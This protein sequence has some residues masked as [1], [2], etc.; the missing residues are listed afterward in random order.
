MV[1]ESVLA[2]IADNPKLPTPRALTLRILERA[3]HPSCSIAEIGKMIAL[4]PALC[5]KMLKLV[6]SSLYGLSRPITSIQRALNLL[7]LN[8]VRSLV[9]SLSLPSL[10]FQNAS[11]EQ[12]KTYWKSSVTIAIVCREMATRMKWHDADSEMVAGLLCD[13]GSLLMQETF[14][15]KYPAMSADLSE[16]WLKR[17]CEIEEETFE[18]DHASAAAYFLERWKL[19]DDLTTAIRFHHRPAD[20]P[21]HCRDR[22]YLIYFGTRI[23]QLM[24]TGGR[25]VL[26]GEIVALANER[27]GLSDEQFRLFLDVLNQKIGDFAGLLDVNLG[28][29]EKFSDLFAKATAN[30][31]QL[32]VETSL[33]HFRIQEEKSQVEEGLK[34]AT[35]ALQMSEERLRQTQKMEAIGRLAGGVAHD[36]NNL[37]TVILGNC[38]LLLDECGLAADPRSLVEMVKQAGERAADLSRQLLAFSRK[39]ILVPEVMNLS[40]TVANMSRMLRRLIGDDIHL[41]ARLADNLKQVK[42]DPSQ[43]EQ[44]IMNLAVNARDAMP[45]G[46]AL[47]IET[48]NLRLG[49]EITANSDVQPGEYSVIVVRDTGCGMD[50]ETLRRIFEPFFT[51]K[52]PGRG[53]G[54]GLATVH[55]IVRQSGGH[56]TVSSVVGQGTVFHIYLPVCEEPV[57]PQRP[58]GLID[59]PRGSE[60][61]LLAEDEDNVRKFAQHTL[62]K[63][64]YKVL[65]AR[66]GVEAIQIDEGYRDEIH[67]LIT[68]TVMPQMSG[69]EL[70]RRIIKHRSGIRVLFMSGYSDEALGRHGVR[71]PLKPF[72]QKPFTP[73]TLAMKTRE[74]LG[75]AALV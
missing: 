29:F 55:G 50:E 23:A 8:H 46:G 68:D 17:Q 24:L 43:L 34:L 52:E 22:A 73:K 47:T 16:N 28:A 36:F 3:S 64:G 19:G 5:G 18:A 49:E 72:L 66:N 58:S 60:T 65:E 37:L 25:P 32:A 26:L 2:R 63:Y 42:I 75:D 35:T 33:D 74:A 38:D 70:A 40:L 39:Q 71:G 51:T 27:Y 69:S 41:V 13:I 14:P 6:N 11:G 45:S 56:V 10:R 7:G 54:L 12:I 61:V 15:E 1:A 20:A 9:L 57:T 48:F 67:L 59:I 44:V 30:L 53:T 31:T 4:D 21:A 62:E